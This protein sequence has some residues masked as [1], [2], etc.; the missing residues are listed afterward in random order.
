VEKP[1]KHAGVL[2]LTFTIGCA[3]F[4]QNAAP[5]NVGL[6]VADDTLLKGTYFPAGKPGPGV[7]LF[8]QSNRTRESWAGVAHQLVSA[9]I[10]VL[11]VDC[12]TN[13]RGRPQELVTVFEFLASQPD[14]NRDLIGIGGAGALGVDNSVETARRHAA[15]VKSL[16]LLSGET[17]RPQLEFLRDSPQLPELFVYSDDDEYPP[18]EE[19]MQLLYVTA[20]SLSKKLVHYPAVEEAAWIWYEPFDTGRVHAHGG[21]GTDMFKPHHELP[22]IP[23]FPRVARSLDRDSLGAGCIDNASCSRKTVLCRR[24]RRA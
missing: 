7:L 4:A 5:R 9:G 20:S 1:A 16:V 8:H 13:K 23:D 15:Q 14:V 18:T 21:H 11:T 2:V 24:T 3:S 22:K 12:E 6:K 17:L 19:A 10:N